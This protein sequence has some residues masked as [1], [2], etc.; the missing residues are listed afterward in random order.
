M[1]TLFRI[2]FLKAVISIV[3]GCNKTVDLISE[4]SVELKSVQPHKVIVP[5]EANLLGEITNIDFEAQECINDGYAVRV[6]VE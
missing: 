1:K 6:I 5:F 4:E 2:F 3:A